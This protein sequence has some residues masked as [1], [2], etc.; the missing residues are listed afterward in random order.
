MYFFFFELISVYL[1]IIKM[2]CQVKKNERFLHLFSSNQSS[3]AAKAAGF[4]QR[5]IENL[6]KCWETVVNNNRKHYS[7]ISCYFF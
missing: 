4:Y 5:G 6:V 2:E 3:K 1:H 7:L